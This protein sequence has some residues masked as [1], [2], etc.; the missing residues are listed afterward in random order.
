MIGKWYFGE[1]KDYELIGF[2][3]WSIVFGQGEYWD[4]QFIGLS[5]MMRVEGYVIDIIIDKCIDQFEKC[6]KVCFFFM[7]CYYKVFYRLWEY[8]FKYKDLY[9]DFVK[10][11]D[12]FIDD[13]KNCVNVVKVV[14]MKVL[15]DFMYVDLGFVQLEGLVFE[16]GVK[17]IDF[18]NWI[19]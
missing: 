8:N 16:V 7:M 5:G 4:F 10:F 19:D 2:D 15:E 13:Y 18:W 17:L 12:I 11:L 1:G 3:Y 14:K 9:K 6:D